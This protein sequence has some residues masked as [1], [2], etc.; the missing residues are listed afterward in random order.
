MPAIRTAVPIPSAR[1]ARGIGGVVGAATEDF[2]L[3]ADFDACW[4]DG[5]RIDTAAEWSSV[6]Q[7]SKLREVNGAFAL[8]W[9]DPDG[10][11]CLARD[12]IGER[13]LFYAIAGDRLIFGS[14]VA[15]ILER[16]LVRPVINHTAVARYLSYGY[17]PG[18]DTLL[19]GIFKVLPGEVVR[20]RAGALSFTSYW[21]LPAETDQESAADE[22]TLR[23]ELR[24]ELEAAVRRRL[25]ERGPVAAFLSGGID[26]S[27][28]VALA[29]RLHP[30]DVFT[31]SV[32][33]GAAYRN[34]LPFS[35]LVADHCGTRHQVVEL[36][37][38]AILKSLDV[39]IASLGD[40]I[41]DPL[42]VPNFLLFQQAAERSDIVLNGEGGDPCF[43]GPKNI[44]MLLADLLGDS[45]DTDA[46]DGRLYQRERSY[47]RAHQK[48][49][50]DLPSMLAP[51]VTSSIAPNALEGELVPLFADPRWTSLIGKLMAINVAF[52]GPF[53][54]LHK[55]DA[56]SAELGVVPRSPLFDRAI[57]EIAFRIPSRL[58]LRGSVEKH[59]LKEAVR[60]LLP[61]V[62]VDRPKSGML[63]PVEGWFKGPLLHHARERLIDGLAPYGLFDRAYL[64]R[65]L[66]GRLPGLRPRRGIKIWMLV[67]LE[68]WLRAT[69]SGRPAADVVGPGVDV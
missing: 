54:I 33:F 15:S 32:S 55:A 61:S 34:E 35:S 59:L 40:P 44:P 56:L 48:C 68:A 50:D 45:G 58:K 22:A 14:N 42:T 23:R 39:S 4:I 62:I 17:L 27:L 69:L 37:P 6:L 20:F 10:A 65:L 67:T 43:G 30:D 41:G 46:D 5:H 28:V 63:V 18:R 47:L 64:E 66:T 57:V 19:C 9:R 60:D 16:G 8:A 25:P 1:T 36:S 53:H 38:D 31:Y 2:C 3:A 7:R 12:H 51:D 29:R 49:F 52:K 24:S 21:L 13:S 11:F 26:S